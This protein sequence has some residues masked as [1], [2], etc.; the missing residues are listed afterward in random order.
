MKIGGFTFIKPGEKMFTMIISTPTKKSVEELL[1]MHSE[2]KMYVDEAVQ[3][4]AGVWTTTQERAYINSV[5]HHR[6][7]SAMVVSN[8][9][10]AIEASDE[11]GDQVGR[12]RLKALFV[13]K[14]RKINLDGLQRDTTIKRFV[15]DEIEVKGSFPGTDG[16]MHTYKEYVTFSKLAEPVRTWFKACP[17]VVTE[18]SNVP[19]QMHSPIFISLQMGTP[20]NPQEQRNALR[21][22]IA[23]YIRVKSNDPR[24]ITDVF[25]RI[26]SYGEKQ[27]RRM[28]H[29]ELYAQTIMAVTAPFANKSI[30]HKEIDAFYM[31]GLGFSE[32]SKVSAYNS[33]NLT[34]H[35]GVW[36]MVANSTAGLKVS[37]GKIPQRTFWAI[38][39][40]CNYLK[41]NGYVVVDYADFA[42]AVYELDRNLVEGSK[43]QQSQDIQDAKT[44]EER[45]VANNDDN[46]Y[47][48]K[49]NRNTS[50]NARNDRSKDLIEAFLGLMK[51]V[52]LVVPLS[53]VYASTAK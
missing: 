23:R 26:E 24:A 9:D 19:D 28:L 29:S 22:P 10:S 33:Q 31:E 18:L 52:P 53:E 21:T 11:H 38:L 49:C 8:I 48:R 51:A 27:Q 30:G 17:I 1:T 7:A 40:I 41:Q 39:M 46:Y 25:N 15:N 4:R 42:R 44:E 35:A 13:Q 37:A 14:Y 3:R 50:G 36:E 43:V 32:I 47:W 16:K 6:A 20:L 12:D 2:V 5:F 45:E 34:H